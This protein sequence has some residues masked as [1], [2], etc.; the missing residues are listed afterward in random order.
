MP[1]GVMHYQASTTISTTR[2]PTTRLWSAIIHNHNLPWTIEVLTFSIKPCVHLQV[3]KKNDASRMRPD[4]NHNNS[5][6]FCFCNS[7]MFNK[8]S[9]PCCGN[10]T[11]KQHLQFQNCS[12]SLQMYAN[13]IWHMSAGMRLTNFPANRL[14]PLLCPKI[15]L[16]QYWCL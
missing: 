8:K 4:E 15:V 1:S 14:Y 9:F 11:G 3:Q 13:V 7:N 6:N 10:L 2:S 5:I 12:Y 16:L